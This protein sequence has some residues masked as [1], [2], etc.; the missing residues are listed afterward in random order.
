MLCCLPLSSCKE[1]DGSGY[2]FRYYIDGNPQN[3][4]PQL[5]VDR[6]AMLIIGN[7]MTGLVKTTNGG[8][9]ENALAESYYV[10]SDGLS[11]YFKLRKDV[12]WYNA[13]TK[14]EAPVTANDFVFAFRRIYDRNTH[15]PYAEQFA[16]LKNA[17]RI[18]DKDVTM[19]IIGASEIGV[20]AP[21]DY[22]L[23]FTL[24]YP[25]AEFLELLATTAAMPCNEEFFTSTMGRYG[26]DAQSCASNGAFYLKEWNYDP[27]W[28]NNYIIMR[29]NLPNNEI[30]MVYPYSLNFFIEKEPETFV[31][32]Y[33]K[34]KSDCV[35]SQSGNSEQFVR[36]SVIT[37]YETISG[38]LV[39]RSNSQYF[40]NY[41]M[42]IALNYAIDRSKLSAS[43]GYVNAKGIVPHGVTL[44][45][46]S[47]RELSSEQDKS[48]YNSIQAMR[49]WH[50]GVTEEDIKSVDVVSILVPDSFAQADILRSIT[51][52]WQSELGL[53][54]GVQVVSQTEYDAKFASGDF[55]IAYVEMSSERN[56]PAAIL[57]RFCGSECWQTDDTSYA[58]AVK[59]SLSSATISQSVNNYSETERMLIDTGVYIPVVYKNVYFAYDTKAQD[60]FADPFT[61]IIDFSQAKYFD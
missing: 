34:G 1:E 8:V 24:D 5:T 51:A 39:F 32:E 3:L 9:L 50:E 35:F 48:V 12:S 29:R 42:R 49:Y 13:A 25:N 31:E 37:P 14:Y 26:L 11:Y 41:K 4:D 20:S 22:E 28:D 38:G 30:N 45:N 23:V 44:L 54:C 6:N 27:Y 59:K 57:E 46:K 58:E 61:G 17:R 33:G 40:R 10:S 19:E 60:I 15:S 16:C 7:M 55:D 36:E 21:S 18:M 52:Q 2:V 43:G 53:M 47:F 56:S